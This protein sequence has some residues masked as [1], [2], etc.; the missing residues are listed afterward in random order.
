MTNLKTGTP[1]FRRWLE[2][3]LIPRLPGGRDRWAPFPQGAYL[4]ESD[5]VLCGLLLQPARTGSTLWAYVDPLFDDGF[6]IMMARS[7]SY[8]TKEGWAPRDPET[9]LAEYAEVVAERWSTSNG[10]AHL[11][12]CKEPAGLLDFIHEGYAAEPRLRLSYAGVEAGCYILLDDVDA[13]R[14]AATV[15]SLD[16]DETSPQQQKLAELRASLAGGVQEAHGRLARIQREQFER[17]RS[18]AGR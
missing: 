15:S 2:N 12:R 17:H 18:L 10:Q 16:L 13:A 8:S 9:T 14:Q 4:V 11:E 1:T 6:P 7:L 3:E 5:W